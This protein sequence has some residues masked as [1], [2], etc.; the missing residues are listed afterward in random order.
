MRLIGFQGTNIK[1]LNEEAAA[2]LG[3]E[4]FSEAIIFIVGRGFLVL[5]NWHH[6]TQQSKKEE[7]HRA[8]WNTLWHEKGPAGTGPRSTTDSGTSDFFL[9]CPGGTV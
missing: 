8:A 7:E 4:L 1:L 6:Q 5:E 9:E 2:E 3:A